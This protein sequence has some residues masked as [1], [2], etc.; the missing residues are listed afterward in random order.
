MSAHSAE[1]AVIGGGLGGVAAALALARAGHQVLVTEETDWLGGQATA[2]AVPLDE[3]PWVES[4]GVTASYRELRD[5]I[6]AY[7]RDN[8]PLTGRAARL[9]LLNPGA[10]WVSQLA[11]EPRVV[12]AVLDSM[13]APHR[14]AGRIRVLTRHVPIAVDVHGDRVRGV[15]LHDL[16]R[17]APTTVEARYVLDATETG[18]LLELGGVEHVTGSEAGTDTGEPHAPDRAR[19]DNLQAF[20]YCFAVEH[21]EG[22][23]HTIDKPDQYVFWRDYQAPF[24]PGR[25]LGFCAPD[26]RTLA[27]LSRVFSPNPPGDPAAVVADQSLPGGDVDL[28]AFRRI[29]AAGHFLPG[30]FASDV[31]LVNWPMNDYWLGPLY[32]VPAEEAAG[33]RNAAK[34]LSLS[35]LYWL[36]TEAPRPDGGCGWP[37]LRLRPDVVGTADGLAKA[38]YVRESR[39]IRAI[40]TVVEQDIALHVRGGH[41]AVTYPD[42]VGVGS[43][44]LDLHPT[45]GGDT[46]LDMGCC[47][48]QIPL[49]ALLPVR[50]TNLL[51]AAK[52]IG[53]THITNGSFRVHPVE[54]NVGEA[55]GH[56]VGFCLRRTACPHQVRENDELLAEFQRR[57]VTAGV[58]L[59]W[60]AVTGY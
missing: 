6:R 15:V 9:A 25:Q 21:R 52:N 54:W 39:R 60:P 38:P 11:C 32:G 34:Q 31:T 4:F 36:Q 48:F 43:Y 33:H 14:A 16:D 5:R 28:W 27:P 26:P 12:L 10:A 7:Y 58:E 50:M 56:L 20:T 53:T 35:L 19:P 2:Q 24:W 23:D 47:P 29:L 57:L 40:T 1:V 49:G 30:A 59:A 46:Y 55:V 45:T 37:G 17:N 22:E 44:H 3:H 51:P 13:L 8:Y 42:S 41:G 18:E